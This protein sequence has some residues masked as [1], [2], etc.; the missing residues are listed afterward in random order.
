MDDVLA[1]LGNT[2]V[3]AIPL[4]LGKPNHLVNAFYRRAC[5]NP[6][7]QLTLL[8]ALTLEK[9]TGASDLER[10]FLQPFVARVFGNYPELEY[11]AAVRKGQLPDNITVEEFF[12][13]PG[14]WVNS[15]YAQ[16]HYSSINYTHVARE[17]IARGVNVVAQMLS[18]RHLQ[19]EIRYSLGCNPDLTLDLIPL[20][21][22]QQA[23]GK[24][25]M[26]VGQVNANLPFMYH[27]AVL[28][29]EDL[30]GVVDN[31]ADDFTLFGPPNMPVA[32]QD[33]L[34]GLYASTLIKDGGTVQI[35]I[36]SLGDAVAY[37]CRL[38][39]HDNARYRT[40]LSHLG[41]TERYPDL[42]AKLGGVAPFSQGLYG[43][44]EM[45]VNGFWHLYQDGILKR[46]VYDDIALQ[47][48]LD[49]GEITEQVTLATLDRLLRDGAIQERL[50]E[51]DFSYLQRFGVF[52]ESLVY[53]EGYI[54]FPG[55]ARCVANLNDPSMRRLIEEQG[56][57]DRLK[58]GIVLHAGFFLGPQSLYRSLADLGEAECKAFCMTAISRVN[59][60][61]GHEQLATRQRRDA[62]F[63]NTTMMM[64][65]LGA[66]VSDGLDNG[67]V[68][69]G[70]GGQYNFV[71]MAHA[72]PGARSILMLRSTR[73]KGDVTHSNLLWNYGHVTIPRH[74]RDIVITEYGIA[75]VR[76]K[77]DAEVIAALLNIAD[78]QYQDELL[79]T[80]KRA[81]KISQDYVIPDQFRHNTA[82]RL[83]EELAAFKSE[84]L[85]PSFPFGSDFTPEEV[86]LA[87]VL[88]SLKS[89]L[90]SF[91]GLLKGVLQAVDAGPIPEAAKPYLE[92]MQLDPPSGWRDEFIQRMILAELRAGGHLAN[93]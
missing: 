72:L 36:G 25:Y 43:S 27:D 33:Y 13:K 6:S 46:R 92:R 53:Q 30:H 66:A 42:I 26:I 20:L 32:T 45:F 5:Q 67:Q 2:L 24:D 78:S 31:P 11:A 15:G 9:P 49:Q 86:V 82:E 54:L 68:V 8:T 28:R 75:D 64:T 44:S 63:L 76:G 34:L 51:R 79:T 40:V 23:Y 90:G 81:G 74:L 80:A 52:R 57:G 71:A 47:R 73:I 37:C 93:D 85:F 50:S 22:A 29:R 7:V 1:K 84:A 87:E 16:R 10:R 83:E 4:G 65:L 88:T 38:R 18:K 41:M 35:G 62:R 69:S 55:N 3:I 59:Q 60:L 21:K 39:H 58:N 14:S 89:R 91:G 70:V 77:P 48:L 17:L 56:L 12:F 61:Y 19:G